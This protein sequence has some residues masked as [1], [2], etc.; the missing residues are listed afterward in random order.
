VRHF[1]PLLFLHVA[2]VTFYGLDFNNS[3]FG[4]SA[5]SESYLIS[6]ALTPPILLSASWL[7]NKQNYPSNVILTVALSSS[8]LMVLFCSFE[9][10]YAHYKMLFHHGVLGLIMSASL[11]F[12]IVCAK[13]SLAKAS[14]VELLYL[15]NFSCVVSLPFIALLL[16]ELRSLEVELLKRGHLKLI[17]S[18]LIVAVIRLASQAVCLCHLKYSTPLLNA[19]VRGFSWIW[20][21]IAITFITPGII[22][23]LVVP[24]LAAFWICGPTFLLTLFFEFDWI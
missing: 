7:T 20:I 15:L 18:I 9:D 6:L 13:Q 3:A 4:I 16:G 24:I 11:A 14:C 17:F 21:T 8:L 23:E 2:V 19:T 5:G 1:R 22:A 10:E 12:F